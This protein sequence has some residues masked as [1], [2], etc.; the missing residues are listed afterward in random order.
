MFVNKRGVSPLIA[1]VL[2][3]AFAVALGAVVMNWGKGYV[4]Q[5]AQNSGQKAEMDLACQT[6]IKIGI[7][8]IGNTEKVCYNSSADY[9]EFMLENTGNEDITGIRM[10]VIDAN[11]NIYDEDDTAF[12]IGDGSVSPKYTFDYSASSVSGSLQLLEIVP[13]ITVKGRS[14]PQPCLKNSVLLDD[15][16]S[17][18]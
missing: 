16:P 14:T 13:M 11:D 9:A 4:E 5:T 2:L 18:T 6:D 10:I 3:I 15:I 12:T 17:C 8:E 7:K 1:T